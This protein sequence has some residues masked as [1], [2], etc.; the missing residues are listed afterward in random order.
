MH[1]RHR[2]DYEHRLHI[3]CVQLHALGLPLS[4]DAVFGQ[5]SDAECRRSVLD[6]MGRA[7]KQGALVGGRGVY[8]LGTLPAALCPFELRPVGLEVYEL[9][10]RRAQR[11][12]PV[13][14]GL[15]S[16]RGRSWSGLSPE[17]ITGLGL[18]LPWLYLPLLVEREALRLRHAPVEGEVPRRAGR[19]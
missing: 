3:A 6:A 12:V 16:W 11:S 5:M 17:P 18:P 15:L 2:R 13:Y 9:T 7:V 8:G 10:T 4:V 1:K 14:R 19:R